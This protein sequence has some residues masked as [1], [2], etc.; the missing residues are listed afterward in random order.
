MRYFQ[1]FLLYIFYVLSR[2][3][4]Q[5]WM[6][7]YDLVLE[8]YD[9]CDEHIIYGFDDRELFFFTFLCQGFQKKL[10]LEN[11]SIVEMVI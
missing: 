11:F 4:G 2:F 1:W 3:D 9:K 8:T 10:A 5:A 6:D 7:I